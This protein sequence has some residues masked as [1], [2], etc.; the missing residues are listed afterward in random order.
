MITGDNNK[1]NSATTGAH[2]ATQPPLHAEGGG[3]E[4]ESVSGSGDDGCRETPEHHDES[5][6]L[7]LPEATNDPSITT[8]K[9]GGTK[10][11]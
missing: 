6:P 5:N 3:G 10:L 2:K 9:L 7:L 1:M 4:N 11:L 8:I